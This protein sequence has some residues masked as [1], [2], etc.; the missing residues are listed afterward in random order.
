MRI[1]FVRHGEPDYIN[2]CLTENGILQAQKTA[3]RLKDERI[4]AIYSSPMGRTR[5]TA[6]FTAEKHGLDII[7]LDFMHEIDWGSVNPE[8]ELEYNGHPWTIGYEILADNQEYVGSDK[9]SEHHYFRDNICMK[10]YDMVSE[11]FD[12]F[13]AGYGITRDGALYKCD[14]EREETIA[15]FA[16]GGSGAVMFAHVFNL[17]F[18]FVLSSMPYGVCSVSVIDF[19]PQRGNIIIPRFEL[20]ND[21]G[22]IA[23]IKPE[24]LVFDK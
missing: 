18:P 7:N 19:T 21:M 6:S 11:K 8:T 16:H 3:E 5:Q 2:D 13:L 9:W 4:S 15:I 10:Y 14:E 23:K 17:P 20:F 12:E 24:K 22:H 1:I